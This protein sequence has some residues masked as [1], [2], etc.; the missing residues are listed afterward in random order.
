MSRLAAAVIA[1]TLA[2]S[3]PAFAGGAVGTVDCVEDP[4]NPQC[5]V[6]VS[7]PA[8]RGSP[9]SAGAAGCRDGWNQPVPCYVEGF[10]WLGEGGCYYRAATGV[11]LEAAIV[12]GGA[13]TPP[14]RWYE[15][16]CGYPPNPLVTRLRVYAAAPGPSLLAE[17]AVRALRLPAPAIRLNPQ[18][19]SPQLVFVPTWLWLDSSSWGERSAT[20]SVP[21]LSLTAT[22]RP[23]RVV[24]STGDGDTVVCGQGTAWRSGTD[25]AAVS[26]DCGHVYSSASRTAPGGRYTV[27]ATI[28]W[29]V[30]WSGGG[31]S[32]TEPALTST[33]SVQVQV[34]EASAVNTR[35]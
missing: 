6:D 11:V 34:V 23:V 5:F 15:G 4:S 33:A 17:Q 20:A 26:P 18:P 1:P 28:T 16:V 8:T 32:G 30:T 7:T 9:G 3:A 12:M 25:P 35:P 14:A 24:W 22:A 19:P 2:I 13:P 27:T 21:G 10:G 31:A 29:Q